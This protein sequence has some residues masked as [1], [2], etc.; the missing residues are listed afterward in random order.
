M[1]A[2]LSPVDKATIRR[3]AKLSARLETEDLPPRKR[4]QVEALVEILGDVLL[5]EQHCRDG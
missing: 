5:E 4:R 1:T 2:D 3:M